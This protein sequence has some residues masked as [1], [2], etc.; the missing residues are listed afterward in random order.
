MNNKFYF[1]NIFLI[2]THDNLVKILNILNTNNQKKNLVITNK[3]NNKI[4]KTIK[5]FTNVKYFYY[6]DEKIVFGS[7]KKF[8]LGRILDH[9][10]IFLNLF[11][12]G[13]KYKFKLSKYNCVNLFYFSPIHLLTFRYLINIINHKKLNAYKFYNLKFLSKE[14]FLSP[15]YSFFFKFKLD[16]CKLSYRDDNNLPSIVGFNFKFKKLE[17]RK[18]SIFSKEFVKNKKKS[19]LFIE[20]SFEQVNKSYSNSVDE[21]VT[22]K[23]FENFFKVLSKNN[24]TIYYKT[25]PSYKKRTRL[26]KLLYKRFF[27]NII[28]LDNIVPSEIYIDNFDIMSSGTT[29]THRS[30][31]KNKIILNFK[32]LYKFNNRTYQKY[33]DTEFKSNLSLKTK[34]ENKFFFLEKNNLQKLNKFFS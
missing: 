7:K 3:G 24:F 32:N 22:L 34:R 11:F 6:L 19:I 26:F 21:K 12:F 29:S 30:Y 1:D 17:E 10:T 13:L 27:K 14:H 4:T 15:I 25:H 23:N 18:N 2:D 5:K 31:F 9:I 16:R 8:I 33:F 20:D 28:L